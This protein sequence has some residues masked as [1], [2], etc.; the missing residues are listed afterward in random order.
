MQGVDSTSNFLCVFDCDGTMVDSQHGIILCMTAAFRELGWDDP[1]AE[2][3]RRCVGLPLVEAIEH[4]APSKPSFDHN[5]ASDYYKTT[6]AQIRADGRLTEDLYEGIADTLINLEAQGWLLGVATGKSR[7]GLDATLAHHNLAHHFVT[8]KTADVAR[9]KPDPDMLFQAMAEAGS[10][11]AS[12]VMIGDTTF[13]IEMA[14][15]ANVT[16]IG[17]SWGYHP[18]SDLRDAG[19][20]FIIKNS[21]ELPDIL[22]SRFKP[23]SRNENRC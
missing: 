4:L 9:G 2:S 10:E 16:A 15:R 18:V 5:K 6:F 19:A 8:L 14:V 20:H 22:S 3:V 7:R 17:V 23:E 1:E 12:T 11:S 21:R 13:D